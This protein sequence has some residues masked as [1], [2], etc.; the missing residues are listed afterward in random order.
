MSGEEGIV[1]NVCVSSSLAAIAPSGWL[2]VKLT[3][4]V[5]SAVM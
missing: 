1:G 4:F 5:V 3:L 2:T